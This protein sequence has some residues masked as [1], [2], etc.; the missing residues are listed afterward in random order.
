MDAKEFPENVDVT[1]VEGAVSSEEDLHKIKTRARAHEN[2]GLAGRL[3]G[4]RQCA[5][6][7]QSLRRKAVLTRAYLENATLRPA[8]SATRSFPPLLPIARPVH[9]VVHG[10]RVRARLPALGRPDFLRCSANCWKAAAGRAR[11]AWPGEARFG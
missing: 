7:A 2:S 9:E 10:G 3:R 8:D 4:H 5:G 1:L 6:H 11:T